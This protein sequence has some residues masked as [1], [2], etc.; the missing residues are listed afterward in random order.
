MERVDGNRDDGDA[1]RVARMAGT[2]MGLTEGAEAR[3][4]TS[5]KEATMDFRDLIPFGRERRSVP[6]RRDR[7]EHPMEMFQR[8]VNQL[9][10]DFFRTPMGFGGGNQAFA[11][12]PRVDVSESENEYEVTAELPGIDEKDIEVTLA[13]NLL[14]IRGEKKAEREEKDKNFYLNERSFGSFRRAVPLPSDVDED[15]VEANFKNGVLT[16]RLPK[17]PE[18]QAKTR[19][20][21]VKGT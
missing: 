14:T 7:G 13:D 18:A 1:A 17:S 16:V 8:E 12:M 5:S 10:D 3:P 15:R 2:G 11:A 6:V 19:R 4:P 20:I 9:F 21:E